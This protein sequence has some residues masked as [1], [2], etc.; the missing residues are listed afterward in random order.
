MPALTFTRMDFGWVLAGIPYGE[1]WRKTRKVLHQQLHA[2]VSP[3]YQPLQL[4]GAREFCEQLLEAMPA[5]EVLPALVRSSFGTTIVQMVY[6]IDI[7][8]EAARQ[9]YI[10]NAD[11][12]LA[13][14]NLAFIPGRF[15]VDFFPWSTLALYR[16]A[17]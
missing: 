17:A 8:N 14:A 9:E 10:D 15:L 1:R 7:K 13:A 6:G 16:T 11:N 5:P 4:K 2:G 3:Q 12:A